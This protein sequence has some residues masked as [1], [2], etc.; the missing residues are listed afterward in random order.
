MRNNRLQ[1]QVTWR[2][3]QISSRLIQGAKFEVKFRGRLIEKTYYSGL[4]INFKD[5]SSILQ[6]DEGSTHY[7]LTIGIHHALLY[8]E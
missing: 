3:G 5:V 4:I 2:S 7:K 8:I 6:N 1:A